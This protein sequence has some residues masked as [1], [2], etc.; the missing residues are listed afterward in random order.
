VEVDEAGDHPAPFGVEAL[1][2]RRREVVAERRDAAVLD[3]HVDARVELRRRV[4][5]PAAADPDP[6]HAPSSSA[7]L[8]PRP[9]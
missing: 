8:R 9:A 6:A 4:E 5:H 3:E 1:G 7:R 2:A